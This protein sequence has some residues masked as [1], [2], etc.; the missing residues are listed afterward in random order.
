[1]QRDPGD[2]QGDAGQVLKG[3]DLVQHDR[4]DERGE[5]RQQRQHQ[6]E[7]RPGQPLS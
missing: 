1:V 7:R 4:L 6:R 5:H 2:D 3:R